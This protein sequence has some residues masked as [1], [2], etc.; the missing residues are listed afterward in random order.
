MLVSEISLDNP[1]RLETKTD[2]H[3]IASKPS[4]IAHY[5]AQYGDVEVT[6]DPT[7][8]VYRVPAFAKQI[9]DYTAA[10]VRDCAIWGSN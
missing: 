3:I 5:I 2:A 10:K 1:V 9:A 6:F 8:N 4:T 7:W